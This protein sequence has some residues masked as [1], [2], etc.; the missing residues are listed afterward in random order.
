M[1][2]ENGGDYEDLYAMCFRDGDSRA[3]K[4]RR[5]PLGIGSR[6]R[7]ANL[8]RRS[9]ME[10]QMTRDQYERH[11]QL[12]SLS[13]RTREQQEELD[14]L[15]AEKEA[16]EQLQQALEWEGEQVRRWNRG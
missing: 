15:D 9:R 4:I 5:S 11:D 3:N 10:R 7:G 14:A 1:T 12:T 13:S 8:F 6:F 2:R 16:C